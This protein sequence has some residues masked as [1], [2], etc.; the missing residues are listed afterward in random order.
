[1]M[2]VLVMD[3]THGG[4]KLAIEFSKL[5][6]YENVYLHDIYN[7][8]KEEELV[9]LDL[10]NIKLVDLEDVDAEELLIISPVHLPLSN[11]EMA[12][13]INSKRNTFITHHEGLKILLE[14]FFKNYDKVPIIEITGVKGK[15]S[16]AFM[17]KEILKDLHPLILSSLGII[18]VRDSYDITLKKNVSITPANIK[19]AI[20]LAYRIDNPACNLG[21]R[22]GDTTDYVK[23]RSVI[24]ESSLGVT[25]IGDVGLL[26]NIVENYPIAKNRSDAKTAKSQVFRCKMVA[27]QKEAL[28]EFYENEAEEFES[29]I[30]TFSIHDKECTVY[31]RNIDYDIDGTSF[32]IVYNDLKTVTGNLSSGSLEI[33]AFAIGSHHVE[34]I[35]GVVT[36]CL[37]LEIPEN[38]IIEGLKNYRGIKGRTNIRNVGK[39]KIIEEVNP[40]INTKAIEFSI[41]ML[42]NPEDYYII[43]GGDYGITC[44]EIDE[45]KVADL[46]NECDDL[47][48]ILTGEVGRNICKKLNKTPTFIENYEDAVNFA[49]DK[50]FNVLFIYRSDYRKLCER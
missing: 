39:L 31:G 50:K 19:E 8:L 3:A 37:T 6:E 12:R 35:L 40:G 46:L 45:E 42:K 34:N 22:K 16:S 30:N 41:G 9:K 4:V 25:G 47:N 18:Q 29:K 38:K 20:D 14:S 24:L 43:I 48:L 15:T 13:R 21:C 28:D 27:I 26:T 33:E 36:V 32:E 23:Y 44:E 2:D 11:D 10:K 5:K 49:I 1:M 7:T 17:L